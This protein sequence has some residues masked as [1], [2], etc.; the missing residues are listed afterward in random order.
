MS[1]N[2]KIVLKDYYVIIKD[3]D[4]NKVYGIFDNEKQANNR[5]QYLNEIAGETCSFSVVP[6]DISI[7][8]KED[9]NG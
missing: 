6:A 3:N 9:T 5:K 8:I 2:D 7:T 4:K 1:N